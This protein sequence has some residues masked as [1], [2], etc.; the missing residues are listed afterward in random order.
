METDRAE[1]STTDATTR[2]HAQA[3]RRLA[4]LARHELPP[5]AP[6]GAA[7]A[8]Y[9]RFRDAAAMRRAGELNAH[10]PVRFGGFG[11]RGF[12]MLAGGAAIVVL[13]AGL[14]TTWHFTAGRP[15]SVVVAHGALDEG[16][17]VRSASAQISNLRFSDGTEVDLGPSSRAR[18]AE[19]TRVGARVLLED[20]RARARVVPRKGAQWWFD[21]G[22]C[23]IQV[24]GTRFDM[25][26]SA[27]LQ[28]LEVMLYNGSVVVKG[29]PATGGVPMRAGQYLVMNVRQGSVRLTELRTAE[30]AATE[31]MP[32]TETAS[33]VAGA[34][35]KTDDQPEAPSAPGVAPPA[36]AATNASSRSARKVPRRD[37]NR[38]GDN[39]GDGAAVAETG[40]QAR[41][42][43]EDSW[44]AR[45]LAGEFRT[46]IREAERRGVDR[47]LRAEPADNLMALADAA[48]YTAS[49]PLARKAL[50]NVRSRFPHT[51]PAYRAA[52][53]LG[54][55]AEDQA[56][57]LAQASEWYDT[58]LTDAPDD[59]FRAEAMGRQMT[60][61]LRLGRTDRA[62]DLARQYL[63]RYP[64][65]AYARAARTILSP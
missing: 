29:P 38:D 16:G 13:A 23:R 41:V 11:F 1:Q 54:R 7:A 30:P 21:A 2:V 12:Q 35:E 53:L 58:Y 20:G 45:V 51:P 46:V 9:A 56:G 15:L 48:R 27:P 25:H 63:R 40:A 43:L 18:V 33:G 10:R 65:G 36:A 8:A 22:P 14:A 62:R 31:A 60:A 17:F 6:E 26:W 4:E 37:S 39:D 59:A 32:V 52:F 24:T 28:V 50:L 55:L 44:P 49:F 61:T 57:N 3:L 64:Q 5:A 19:T 47:V 42:Q 34:P